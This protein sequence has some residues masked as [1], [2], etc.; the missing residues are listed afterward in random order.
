MGRY[1]TP[2]RIS[3]ILVGQLTVEN[4]EVVLDLGA[5][6]GSLSLAAMERWRFANVTAVDSDQRLTKLAS[7]ATPRLC[8]YRTD[9]LALGLDQK[10]ALALEGADA[11]VCNPPFIKPKWRKDFGRLFESAGLSHC[12]TVLEEAGATVLF[13]AQ[14]LRFLRTGGQLGLIVPDGLVSG[15]LHKTLR[16]SLL[17]NHS[18]SDVIELPMRLFR[19]AEVKAHIVILR[20]NVPQRDQPI[21]LRGFA[22]GFTAARQIYSDD[23]VHRMDYSFY[24]SR[25][26]EPSQKKGQRLRDVVTTLERGKTSSARRNV[27]EKPI[28]HTTDFPQSTS[29]NISPRLRWPLSLGIARRQVLAHAGDILIARVGRNLSEKVVLVKNG[30]IAISDCVYRIYIADLKFRSRAFDFLSSPEGRRALEARSSGS[31]ARHLSM[32][33]LLDLRMGD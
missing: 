10:I 8:T 24:A 33:E 11:G 3:E 18:I 4:P 5:G 19:G 12:Y 30:S 23:A 6:S 25:T 26:Q 14:N 28:F 21:V 1:Y 31:A 2:T 13:L 9:A 22:D 17:E 20:K 32:S 15:A 27:Y 16:R 29:L 7:I